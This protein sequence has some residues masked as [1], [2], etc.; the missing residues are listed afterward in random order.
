MSDER[1]IEAGIE[2]GERLRDAAIARIRNGLAEQGE[3]LCVA[4]DTEIPAPRRAALPSADRCV[5]CQADLEKR[6]ARR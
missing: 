5:D 6:W 3:D 1:W 2:T 4:C